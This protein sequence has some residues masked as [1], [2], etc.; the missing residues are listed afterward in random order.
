[1]V[2]KKLAGILGSCIVSIIAVGVTAAPNAEPVTDYATLLSHLRDSCASIRQERATQEPFFDVKGRR[3]TVN[4]STIEVYEY[5]SVE[6][7]EIEASC[8]S[9][10]GCSFRRGRGDIAEVCF[11]DWIATPHFYKTGRVIVLYCGD[12]DSIITLL[13]NALGKQFAGQTRSFEDI[14]SNL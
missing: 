14:M 7:M 2:S 8:V 12:N 10:E 11:V 1:M 13:E 6:A 9:P 5:T 3:I 4:E